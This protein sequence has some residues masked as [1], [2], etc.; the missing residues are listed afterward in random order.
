M[1]KIIFYSAVLLTTLFTIAVS[2][3]SVHCQTDTGLFNV[4]VLVPGMTRSVDIRQADV[5]PLG[6]PVFFIAVLGKGILGISLKKDD[7]SGDTIFML[8]AAVS[9]SG[10][11]PVCRIGQSK[12]MIDQMLEIKPYGF[13]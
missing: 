10:T 5:F 4:Q 8:G 9:A 11:V 6:C 7:A 3:S 1:G 2:P 12:G 13:I